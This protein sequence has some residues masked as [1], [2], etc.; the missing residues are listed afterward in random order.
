LNAC[1]AL[2]QLGIR[3]PR[4]YLGSGD[5]WKR[6]W[7]L[8][9]SIGIT[10]TIR[11]IVVSHEDIESIIEL[12]ATLRIETHMYRTPS[13]HIQ[14]SAPS[15][16]DFTYNPGN[17]ANHLPPLCLL[18]GLISFR[19]FSNTMPTRYSTVLCRRMRTPRLRF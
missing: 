2:E 17:P 8:R 10:K 11:G 9:E 5:N 19:C 15:D 3:L 13:P 14:P 18:P 1:P 6:H 7:T 12:Q 16:F 4:F